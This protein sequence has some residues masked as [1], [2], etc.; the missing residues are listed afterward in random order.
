MYNKSEIM[1]NAWT[2][3]RAGNEEGFA[4]ALRRAWRDA[5]VA[6]LDFGTAATDGMTRPR[7]LPV[8]NPAF[9]GDVQRMAAILRRELGCPAA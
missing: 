4:A 8:T 5:F 1:K 3:Y 6:A 7:P 9:N 2:L